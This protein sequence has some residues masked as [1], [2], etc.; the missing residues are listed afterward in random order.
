MERFLKHAL[1]GALLALAIA[2]TLFPAM[3]ATGANFDVVVSTLDQV[4][5]PQPLQ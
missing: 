4:G 1:L 3:R 5:A 2:I